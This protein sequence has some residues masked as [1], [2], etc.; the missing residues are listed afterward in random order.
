MEKKMENQ[1][2]TR[3]YKGLCRDQLGAV[4]QQNER[5]NTDYTKAIHSTDGPCCIL[6]MTLG[7]RSWSTLASATD[8]QLQDFL[9][10]VKLEASQYNL[11][12][13]KDKMQLIVGQIKSLQDPSIHFTDAN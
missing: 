5:L 4:I 10:A 13:N 9:Y 3:V 1:M 11:T 12:V 6:T 7:T 8:P 2:T